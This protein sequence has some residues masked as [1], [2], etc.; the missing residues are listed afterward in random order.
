MDMIGA[1][2]RDIAVFLIVSAAGLHAVPGKD[3]R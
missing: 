2:I 3:Y 1:W